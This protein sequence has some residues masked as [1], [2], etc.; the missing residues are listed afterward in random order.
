MNH[1]THQAS[2]VATTLGASLL[3]L[4]GCNHY[5]ITDPTTGK[6]YYTT[7]YK[8]EEGALRFKDAQSNRRVRIQNSEV[9]KIRKDE[10]LQATRPQD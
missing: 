1:R 5:A 8:L 4:A 10:F 7:K 2:I 6:T 3:L 9:A